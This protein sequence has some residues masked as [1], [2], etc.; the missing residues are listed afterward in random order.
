MA[1]FS[2]SRRAHKCIQ[3]ETPLISGMEVASLLERQEDG[4]WT[5]AD[6]CPSCWTKIEEKLEGLLKDALQHRCHWKSVIPEK[7]KQQGK[8]SFAGFYDK[9]LQCLKEKAAA[10]S[11]FE[12]QT[13]Q[14][15][16][17]YLE[18]KRQLVRR[19]ELKDEKNSRDFF[20]ICATGEIV[21]VTKANLV[22]AESGHL[23]QE[24][25]AL[26]AGGLSL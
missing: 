17:C 23:E 14:L 1:L 7:V 6:Y 3:D 4:Q 15:L 20:E 21:A 10:A 24:L 19:R 25:R 12:Q 5:R 18:R 9:L 13:A 16:A 26:L 8:Q 11:P 22:G 2:I